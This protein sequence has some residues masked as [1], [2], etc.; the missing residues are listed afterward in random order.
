ML[1]QLIDLIRKW[2]DTA[3]PPTTPPQAFRLPNVGG[4]EVTLVRDGWKLQELASQKE[5]P[6]ATH[7]FDD[8]PSLAAWL[9]RYAIP[10]ETQIF[11]TQA[12]GGIVA[13]T[14]LDWSRDTLSCVMR[15]ALAWSEWTQAFGS[16]LTQKD[17]YRFLRAHRAHLVGDGGA[18]RVLSGLAQ[19]EVVGSSKLESRINERGFLEFSGQSGSR[20]I[21]GSVPTAF[22]IEI[23]AYL[24]Q[25]EVYRLQVEIEID[26]EEG[27][28]TFTLRAPLLEE[29]ALQAWRAEVSKLDRLL[30]G[31][32]ATPADGEAPEPEQW[33]IY[34]GTLAVSE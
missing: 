24:G 8:V 33:L 11:A 17:L 9:L 13:I 30:N 7:R 27:P 31:P 22:E 16:E 2:A 26:I 14:Q 29:V 12:A 1:A 25:P 4:R 32:T 5:R 23:P 21:T 34:S 19:L 10:Q 3:Q 18:D 15:R 20:Q 6:V 28:P